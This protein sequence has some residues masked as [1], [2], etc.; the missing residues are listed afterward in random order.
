MTSKQPETV[1]CWAA[2]L[3]VDVKSCCS[4]IKKKTEKVERLMYITCRQKSTLPRGDRPH[5]AGNRFP[6]AYRYKLKFCP[7]PP[8][9]Q[10]PRW[11]TLIPSVFFV[12]ESVIKNEPGDE[13]KRS[14]K[15]TSQTFGPLSFQF[16]CSSFDLIHTCVSSQ[17]S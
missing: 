14:L 7:Y 3:L 9:Y 17:K 4:T 12:V 15:Q 2:G 10:W 8:P 1:D 13:I 5:F 6:L 16:V 11:P